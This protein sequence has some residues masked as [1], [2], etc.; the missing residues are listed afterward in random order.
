MSGSEPATKTGG[1]CISPAFSS[2]PLSL[3]T[4]LL[5]Y[6]RHLELNASKTS[7]VGDI[8]ASS[9]KETE[10][11]GFGTGLL[12]ALVASGSENRDHFQRL[13]A[14]AL[15]LGMITGNGCGFPRDPDPRRGVQN[16]LRPSGTLL[17]LASR[18]IEPS[19][20][21]PEVSCLSLN[22]K[23][24]A[25]VSRQAYLSVAYDDNCAT[26]TTSATSAAELERRLKATGATATKLGLHGRFH[27]A[28][29][30]QCFE[31]L[32][33]FCDANEAFQL[34]ML[35]K[36]VI[37]IR[38]TVNGDFLKP[39]RLHH[40]ALKSILVER[41]LWYQTFRAAHISSCGY[42]ELKIVSCGIE[43]CVPP[44]LLPDLGHQVVHIA[45]LDRLDGKLGSAA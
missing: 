29:H 32:T 18:S 37:P 12:S 35:S 45:D 3:L 10:S 13:G 27:W 34:P 17:K 43:K 1:R 42:G 39:G 33:A 26:I 11:L 20:K 25:E 9:S 36:V 16:H 6:A 40:E 44:S 8:F 38:S 24:V 5:D 22:C 41:A 15:R 14:T 30:S 19:K 21:F 23:E 7:R 2:A 28:T 4:Q 31:D